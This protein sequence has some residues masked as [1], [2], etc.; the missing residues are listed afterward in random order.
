MC[1]RDRSKEYLKGRKLYTVMGVITMF[2]SGGIIPT[3]LLIKSLG[4]LNSFWVYIIPALFSYYDMI[5]LMNFFRQ[6]PESL[7]EAARIDGAGVWRIFIYVI[8]PTSCLLYT[9]L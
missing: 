9:S 8:L 2:F 5:I 6:V 3:Y 7:E 1:I 4:M